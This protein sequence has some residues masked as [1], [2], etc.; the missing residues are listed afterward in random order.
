MLKS[1]RITNY[2]IID[3]I[4]IEFHKEMTAF[5]GET[6]A[7]KSII[8]D[9]IGQLL[10]QRASADMVKTGSNKAFIEGVFDISQ[11]ASIKETLEEFGF[12]DI[13]NDI[14]VSKT[15]TTDGKSTCRL[16]YR[17]VN[18]TI[19][20][21][22]IGN[23][24]DIHSQFETQ[25]LLNQKIH[26]DLLDQYAANEIEVLLNEYQNQYK[27]YVKKK[28]ELKK[29]LEKPLDQ[30]ELEYLES[31]LQEIEEASIKEN[32]YDDLLNEK[33]QMDEYEKIN[34][35][36]STIMNELDGQYG[37]LPVLQSSL[38]TLEKL[39]FIP[40]FEKIYEEFEEGYYKIQDSYDE[41]Q[42]YMQHLEFDEYRYQEIQERMFL[43]QRI[44]KKFGY[45][46]EK[47]NEY[48]SNLQQ[49]IEVIQNQDTYV[50]TLE[51]DI[52]KLKKQA[53][54]YALKIHEVR[55]KYALIL[56]EKIMQQLHDLYMEKAIFTIRIQKNDTLNS[57]GIY[58]VDFLISTNLGQSLKPLHK[59]ASGGELSRLMLG[60]KI[61]FADVTHI[62]TII[63]DEVDTG[64]SGK[65]ADRIGHKMKE[66]SEHSQVICIT[67]LP[68]VASYATHHLFVYKESTSET[69]YT[70][71]KYLNFDEKIN[72]IATMLSG[73]KIS[74]SS[75]EA[76]KDL[77]T[78]NGNK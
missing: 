71:T 4:N 74:S 70:K 45:S 34:Q 72:E 33:K 38:H 58:T 21:E 27:E 35:N 64:V 60:L 15:I 19:L 12:D 3:E 78:L 20:K 62:S 68:Q 41:M 65:I 69:T 52:K 61:V 54:D 46:I 25:Y 50:L 32:E 44:Q 55:K 9:A 49:K 18:V 28:N 29:F 30:E 11:K 59:V 40:L 6:G 1:L 67:H 51:N 63:F 5:T 48:K 23:M 37:S 75:I 24:V 2:A 39:V 8:I 73:D 13:E 47:I 53:L 7:G 10:G 42:N 43:I 76:A 31:Q 22:I 14:V 36:L 57:K 17:I 77:L 66:L 26:I 56:E 16:N